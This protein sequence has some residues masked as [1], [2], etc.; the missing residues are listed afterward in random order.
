MERGGDSLR[1]TGGDKVRLAILVGI[2][3]IGLTIGLRLFP[4]VFPEATIRFD[5]DRTASR[6]VAEEWLRERGLDAGG[7][8][9]AAAFIY[10]DTAK[11]FLERE[12]GLE[13]MNR[14]VESTARIWAWSHRWF[15]P[16]QKEE[17]RVDVSPAGE[18]IG[19]AHL[20]ADS[21]AGASLAEEEALTIAE[22]FLRERGADVG[23]ALRLLGAT[24]KKLDARTDHRF[25]WERTD[26]DWAGGKYRHRVTI[27]GDRIGGYEE[28]VSVP[29][30]WSRDYSRLRSSNTLAGAVS[31][32]FLIFTILVMLVVLFR[33]ARRKAI[34]WRFADWLGL[35]GG[36]L[37]LLAG[38]NGLPQAL[39]RYDT[40]SSFGGFL[41]ESLLGTFLAAIG[42]GL[43]IVIVVATG[44]NRY[45]A[46][47]PG[48]LSLPG[49]L[50]WRGI[51]TKE[52]LFSVLA[53][54]VLT[55]LFLAYQTVF[56]RIA[57]S[58]GAWSPADVPY[59][60]LLNS[61]FPLAFLLFIGFFPSVTEEFLSRA[62]SIPLFSRIFRSRWVGVL[63]A[64]AI[65]AF[66]HSTYPNQPFYIRGLE[67][68]IAGCLISLVMIRFNLLTLLVWH[69]TVD[70]T[71]SGYLLFRSGNPYYV[72]SAVVAGGIFL[73]PILVA[74][75]SYLRTGAFADPHP[76]RHASEPPPEAPEPEPASPRPR[77]AGTAGLGRRRAVAALGITA[78]ALAALGFASWT[79]A[80]RM[81]EVPVRVDR[82]E[83]EAIAERSLQGIDIEPGSFRRAT[84]LDSGLDPVLARY[85]LAHGGVG[86]LG[87]LCPDPV[88]VHTWRI[89]SFEPL[90]VE[91]IRVGVD[92]TTGRVTDLLH[93]IAESESLATLP[94]AAAESVAVSFLGRF[95]RSVD[96]LERT[97]IAEEPK[98]RRLDRRFVWETREGDERSVGEGRIR[99]TAT[100]AGSAGVAFSE[101][102]RVPEE[103][104]R[105]REKRTVL[106]GAALA[107]LL[108]GMAGGTSLCIR[109]ALRAREA[110]PVPW[111]RFALAGAAALVVSFIAALNGLP[112]VIQR[113]ETT[114]P[115]GTF[116]VLIAVGFATAGVLYFFFAWSSLGLAYRLHP[117]IRSISDAAERRR[118]L[119]AALLALVGAPIWIGAASTLGSL[120]TLRLPGI[121]P[122]PDLGTTA[123]LEAA[124]PALGVVTT[125]LPRAFLL[126]LGGALLAHLLRRREGERLPARAALPIAAALGFALLS[127]RAPGEATVA[128]VQIALVAGAALALALVVLR[129][130]PLAFLFAAYGLASAQDL[131]RMLGQ[132]SGWVATHG[133]LALALLLAPIAALLIHD[134]RAG[135]GHGEGDGG[136]SPPREP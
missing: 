29:E 18:V 121:G 55:C 120:I 129:A 13:E 37:V 128:L 65:W 49:V 28:Y 38:L 52:F 74:L 46:A 106:W 10:A 82:S 118:M 112:R 44:E 132:P 39:Y 25:T 36:V 19:F 72:A 32:V 133:L 111:R 4:T 1:L 77:V 33:E 12:L 108:A 11:V 15:R 17:F 23:G 8:R 136:S 104:R 76:L 26:V 110:G 47:F 90:E 94:E 67:L 5:V 97:E 48:K 41:A 96:G 54:I 87:S 35:I 114:I 122:L 73:L 131:T 66:G 24:A 95:G 79:L 115:W 70:A 71:Y 21:A 107:L 53:G 6:K 57:Y 92:A 135:R 43:L 56:Y 124:V 59:D 98:E 123:N 78:V 105:E 93:R 9:H 100:I 109:D 16:L 88:T 130:N 101:G 125:V 84:G 27:R 50:S 3:A 64:S 127:S 30:A 34:R 113:Y 81:P 68:L 85:L 61:V 75:I 119:P 51:R 83:A 91:E 58:L 69:Y 14:V 63:L 2:G 126:A 20:L 86:V 134:L 60:D 31:S 7:Y 89:R 80:R 62:F 116:Q 40:T 117:A 22:R 103:F 42:A 45:R 99:L 102:F